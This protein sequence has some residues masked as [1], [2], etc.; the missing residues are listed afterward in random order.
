MRVMSEFKLFYNGVVFSNL[1]DEIF[2]RSENESIFRTNILSN[3]KMTRYQ[4][5]LSFILS[6]LRYTLKTSHRLLKP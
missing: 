5:I 4:I 2:S 6:L 3:L 1:I